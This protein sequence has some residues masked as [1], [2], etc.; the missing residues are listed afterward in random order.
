MARAES[1]IDRTFQK[2]V[3]YSQY[4]MYKQC[5][6][7]WYLNYVKK[8][9]IF[10]PSVFLTFGTSLHETLQNYLEV[11]YQDSIKAA[12]SIDLHEHLKGRM[13]ENYTQ[14]IEENGGEHFITKEDFSAFIQDGC[15]ILDWVR[16][17]RAQY[18]S[19][20]TDKLVGIEIPLMQP[21]VSDIP[22]VLMQGFI[23]LVF[24]NKELD[25][26]TVYDIKTSTTGWKDKDKADSTKI[27]Q[28]LLYKH[29]YSK[30]LDVPM[31]KIEV[32]FFIVKR[33][34]F[35]S[36]DFPTK[37][38]QEF[39]PAQGKKKTTDAIKEFESFVRDCFTVDA[40]Y[41]DKEYP[42]NPLGCKWCPF[43]DRKDL[44]DRS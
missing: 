28:L 26:Y 43:K 38:V 44:C 25:I 34:P 14:S 16:K 40:E 3:S 7:Q 36:E 37:W 9:K 23:D 18:F 21:I 31:E 2:S 10:K 39:K 5:N 20:K 33:R 19:T 11:M 35:I 8:Q 24:Y 41:I 30:E 13:I 32:K 1:K 22:N 17:H 4:S 29:F 27:S 15:N 42:K 12:D 6:Y